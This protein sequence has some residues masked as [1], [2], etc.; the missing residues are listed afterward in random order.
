MVIWSEGWRGLSK[1][2]SED[3]AVEGKRYVR[4]ISSNLDCEKRGDER[5]DL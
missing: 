5:G 1:G 2:G 3:Q 4:V